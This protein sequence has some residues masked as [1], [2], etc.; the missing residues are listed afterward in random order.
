MP[1]QQLSGSTCDILPV[2]PYEIEANTMGFSKMGDAAEVAL[3]FTKDVATNNLKLRRLVGDT[4]SS[5]LGSS[6]TSTRLSEEF[7]DDVDN[8][9]NDAIRSIS[10]AASTSSYSHREKS[11]RLLSQVPTWSQLD[12]TAKNRIMLEGQ[13]KSSHVALHLLV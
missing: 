10:C 8:V 9:V 11:V 7:P 1:N 2:N 5:A 3:P 4:R 12:D 13:G 6:D